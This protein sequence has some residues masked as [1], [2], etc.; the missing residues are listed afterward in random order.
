MRIYVNFSEIPQELIVWPETSISRQINEYSTA[1]FQLLR[2]LRHVYGTAKYGASTY[3][4]KPRHNHVVQI[5]H[6]VDYP[7]FT[8]IIRTIE[9]IAAPGEPPAFRYTCVDVG[10]GL[11][12]MVLGG[13]DDGSSD[14]TQVFNI[15][16]GAALSQPNMFV[17]ELFIEQLSVNL[18]PREYPDSTGREGIESICR[19]TGGIWHVGPTGIFHY[20]GPAGVGDALELGLGYSGEITDVSPDNN[21]QMLN[22]DIDASGLATFVSVLSV[23]PEGLIFAS[24]EDLLAK[25]R[26]GNTPVVII[27]HSFTSEVS[28]Q[29]RATAELASR[30]EPVVVGS[31]ISYEHS[32]E[33]GQVLRINNTTHSVAGDYMITGKQTRKVSPG[34]LENTIS[35]GRRPASLETELKRL[36]D[37]SKVA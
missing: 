28:A 5:Y 31:F 29:Q 18:G 34:L 30:S 6:D 21:H 36:F 1:T 20:Y 4:F 16:S 32:V 12:V 23:R 2:P 37:R 27:D 11:E 10:I 14:K 22:V 19:M 13:F 17:S 35:F 25:Q 15:A 7:L 33:I 26:Y 3:G 24:A 9:S 8:G